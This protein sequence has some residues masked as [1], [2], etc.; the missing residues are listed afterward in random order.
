MGRRFVYAGRLSHHGGR[1]DR[2]QG[3]CEAHPA[4]RRAVRVMLRFGRDEADSFLVGLNKS[5]CRLF[6][7]SR[8]RK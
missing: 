3:G 7:I 5:E 2:G 4:G 6:Q 1:R 8:L